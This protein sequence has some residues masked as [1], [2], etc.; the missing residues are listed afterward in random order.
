MLVLLDDLEDKKLPKKQ[1]IFFKCLPGHLFS[2]SSVAAVE[3]DT[4]CS[5]NQE[6]C[7]DTKLALDNVPVWMDW[8]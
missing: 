3:D 8:H 6:M 5:K 2:L 4:L 1:C 7:F